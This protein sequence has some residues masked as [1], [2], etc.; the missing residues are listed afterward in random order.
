MKKLL[1]AAVCLL[2]A[3]TMAQGT[4]TLQG[5]VG[6][7]NAPAK[8]YLS[9]SANSAQVTDSAVISGGKF[10]FTGSIT[11][12]T[13]A[14]IRVKHADVVANVNAKPGTPV[15]ATD[16]LSFYLEPKTLN[17]VSA[18]DSVK[19]AVIKGSKVN[20]D[21]VAYKALTKSATDK[22]I[23]LNAEYRSKTP[24]Q[25]KDTTYMKT[26]YAR[27]AAISKEISEINKKFYA[28]NLNSYIG[29]VAYRST[30]G[31]SIN[32]SVV[33]PEFNKFS[34]EVKASELGKSIAKSIESAKKTAVGVMAMD[35]TQNDV[36][37]KPV[38]L[39]D[40]KGKYVLL[41]F[42]ASWCGPCRAENPNVVAAF[43]KYKDKNFTVLGV[44]L[45]QPGKKDLWLQA[46]EKDG[47][48]WTHV[49]DL[50]YWNNEVSK[51]YGIQAI[52]ANFLIDPTGKI[53][54]K[55]IRGEELQKKLAEILGA[56]QSK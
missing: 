44:S 14:Y 43:N 10:T 52:P 11:G 31:Y 40:F 19:Y 6:K 15:P 38:K 12:I 3:A 25:R 36:N 32:P 48:T 26:V 56:G 2:P 33:E 24:E 17:L 49:S 45:D 51:M 8:A 13:S 21:N 29:L 46:I 9:Y 20:E 28:E 5:K 41:D 35:F 4:F 34:A 50:K 18:T 47:L 37:D 55:D 53:V 42:W 16:V 22:N 1:I 39:S 7:L 27:D 23:A 54:A 30:M